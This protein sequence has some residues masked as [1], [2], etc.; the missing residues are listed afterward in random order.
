MKLFLL[1]IYMATVQ[2]IQ[3]INLLKSSSMRVRRGFHKLGCL[4]YLLNSSSWIIL[5]FDNP[6]FEVVEG[7]YQTPVSKKHMKGAKGVICFKFFVKRDAIPE[8]SVSI[9]IIYKRPWEDE[10]LDT[11]VITITAT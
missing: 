5:P 1:I 10:G 8:E 2:S 11:K 7:G 3:G 6:H 4:P 9:S